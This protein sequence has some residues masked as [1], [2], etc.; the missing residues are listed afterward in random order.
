M[1]GVV[2]PVGRALLVLAG[3]A[4]ASGAM[5]HRNDTSFLLGDDVIAVPALAD[6]HLHRAQENGDDVV[7]VRAVHVPMCFCGSHVAI[8]LSAF[9]LFCASV[10][11][12]QNPLFLIKNAVK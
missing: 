7:A 11:I 5:F 9:R 8:L 2:R 10:P 12:L 4:V 3:L 1:V 6:K